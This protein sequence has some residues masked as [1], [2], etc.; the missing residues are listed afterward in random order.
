MK[1]GKKIIGLG[2][3]VILGLTL[4]LI[5]V[6]NRTSPAEAAVTWA[7]SSEVTLDNELYVVD[8]WVIRESSTSYKMWYTHGKKDLS[9]TEI[10][11][12]ITAILTDNIITDI[13]NLDL[14]ALLNDLEGLN[15]GNLKTLLSWHQYLHRR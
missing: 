2:I 1:R 7:K 5:P 8:A 11:D 3:A 12:A 4:I 9:I 13:A 15:V 6:L 14:E 10:I